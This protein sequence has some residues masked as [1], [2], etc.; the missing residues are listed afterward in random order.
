MK[1]IRD[2][3][4]DLEVSI[5]EY[6]VSGGE[7]PAAI[8]CDTIIRLIPGVMNNETSALLDSFQDNLLL[9]NFTSSEPKGEPCDDALADLFGEPNPIVVLKFSKQG[10]FDTCAFFKSL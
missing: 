7:L 8:L 6:V 4:V 2:L 5:G 9:V 3:F 10:T 1:R